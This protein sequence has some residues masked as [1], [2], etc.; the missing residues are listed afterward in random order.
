MTDQPWGEG[1]PWKT[2]SSFFS[3]IR[4][5]LRRGWNTNP[6]KLNKL[7]SKRY[8]IPNPNPRGSR[9]TVWGADCEVCG[10]TFVM[11]DINVDHIVPAGQLNKRE[12]I[13][14]FVER[15]LFITEDSLRI[16]CVDCNS[17]LAYAERYGLTYEQAKKE[18]EVIAIINSGVVKQKAFLKKHGVTPASTIDKRREQIRDIVNKGDEDE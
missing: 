12:D 6:I 1:T 7:K 5:C 18:K 15:L 14:G 16:V 3:Y 9:K 8:Q 17:A 10:G 13:Q 11:K 4:G 2:S